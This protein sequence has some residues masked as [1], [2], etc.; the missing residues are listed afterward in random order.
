MK[1][2]F[3]FL[4]TLSAFAATAQVT[5]HIETAPQKSDSKFKGGTFTDPQN[6]L[7]DTIFIVSDGLPPSL[8]QLSRTDAPPTVKP[9]KYLLVFK[10]KKT[11]RF[12]SEI[13]G[14]GLIAL[15]AWW[16]GEAEYY[17]RYHGTTSN[18]DAYH[19]TRDASLV[20]TGLGCIGVGASFA[21]DE[22]LELWEVGIKSFAMLLG[23]RAI[24][25]ARYNSLKE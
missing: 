18:R 2:L 4:L 11:A 9:I 6:I 10:Q 17:S 14:Y 25:E 15:G 24:S 20:A 19:V 16:G 7:A 3:A 12:V 23:R 13:A 8:Y 5:L 1:H 21:L 22:K